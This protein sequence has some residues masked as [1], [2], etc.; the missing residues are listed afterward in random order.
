MTTFIFYFRFRF[1]FPFPQTFQKKIPFFV[2]FLSLSLLFFTLCFLPSFRLALTVI[3]AR[4]TRTSII[5]SLEWEK[6]SEHKGKSQP[7]ALFFVVVVTSHQQG[8]F[9]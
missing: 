7:A 4:H 5:S 1:T 9:N 6:V 3:I 8:L 2:C